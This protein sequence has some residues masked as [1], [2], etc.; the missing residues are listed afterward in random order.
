[1]FYKENGL[2][3]SA[4]CLFCSVFAFADRVSVPRSGIR[5]G[6]AAETFLRKETTPFIGVP[7]E[8]KPKK[9]RLNGTLECCIGAVSGSGA[10]PCLPFYICCGKIIPFV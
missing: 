1:M 9:I 3:C 5:F 8:G 7:S 4:V 10:G 2:F 6:D